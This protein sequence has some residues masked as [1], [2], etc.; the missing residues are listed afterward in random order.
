MA[1][2]ILVAEDDAAAGAL[3]EAFLEK[4]GFQVTVVTDGE[5]A[6]AAIS[7]QRPFDAVILDVMMP[8]LTGLDVLKAARQLDLTVPIIMVTALSSPEQIVSALDQ[9]ADDYVTKPYNLP[10][11][12]ARLEARLRVSA[13]RAMPV[14]VPLRALPKAAPPAA[15]ATVTT[16]G[17]GEGL[18]ARLKALGGKLMKQPGPALELKAGTWLADRYQIEGPLGAGAFGTVYR[19]RHVDLKQG[20]A[21]KVLSRTGPHGS[22][23]AL[24]REAQ[25]ACQVRHPNAVRVF[26]FGLLPPSSAFLVMELLDGITLDATLAQRGPFNPEVA[27]STV[28]GVLGALA[29]MH[30]QGLVHRDVKPANVLMHRENGGEV[31]KLVDF[32]TARSL[33]EPDGD[34]LVGSLAYLSPERLRDEEYDGRADVYACGVMLYKLLTGVLPIPAADLNDPDAI[35]RWHLKG[36]VLAPS[37]LRPR[38][39][40]AIDNLMV[41]L[42]AKTPSARPPADEAESLVDA[43]V[44]G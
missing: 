1:R 17:Q 26:D 24:R 3:L 16:E 4:H 28:R 10:V 5:L 42:L 11:L 29:V 33:D 32:G 18:V 30:R 43:V 9:G 6:L 14:R 44:W 25:S 2:Q 8:R 41:Q 19:A 36:S 35:A 39:S 38:I 22:I 20:V 7:M 23:E 27:L 37:T 12:L 13:R 34:E 15:V 21:I 31:P 40:K